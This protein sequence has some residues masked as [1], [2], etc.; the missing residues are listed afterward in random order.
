MNFAQRMRLIWIDDRLAT[1]GMLRR[2]EVAAA[3]SISVPQASNDFGA[4]L[5]AFPDLMHYDVRQRCYVRIAAPAAFDLATRLAVRK[6]R[7]AVDEA[8]PH[9]SA[10]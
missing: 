8:I 4:F 1:E 7:A 2:A 10:A 9:R 6:A 5:A 3:F